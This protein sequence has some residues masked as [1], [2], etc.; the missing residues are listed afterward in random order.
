MHQQAALG[1]VAYAK[2]EL[3]RDRIVEAWRAFGRLV[4]WEVVEACPL[5]GDEKEAEG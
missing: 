1:P 2:T 5:P 4:Y 3:D